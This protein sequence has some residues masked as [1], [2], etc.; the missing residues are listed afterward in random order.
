MAFLRV[1]YDVY[2]LQDFETSGILPPFQQTMKKCYSSEVRRN[3]VVNDHAPSPDLMTVR[4]PSS[5]E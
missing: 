2:S 5:P 4:D 3:L 1:I